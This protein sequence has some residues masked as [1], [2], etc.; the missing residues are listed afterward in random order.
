MGYPPK[1]LSD[2]VITRILA[3]LRRWH[4]EYRFAYLCYRSSFFYAT[5]DPEYAN[6][7]AAIALQMLQSFKEKEP[8]T[9]SLK[10]VQRDFQRFQSSRITSLNWLEPSMQNR[11]M[12]LWEPLS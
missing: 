2:Q 9:F 8:S 10:Q 5:Q 4:P 1:A 11:W 12:Q 3:T 7:W 6:I